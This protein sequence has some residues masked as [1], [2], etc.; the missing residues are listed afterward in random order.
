MMRFEIGWRVDCCFD[1]ALKGKG[2]RVNPRYALCIAHVQ[3]CR[4]AALQPIP[5]AF[6][7]WLD[8]PCP[9]YT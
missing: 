1:G 6:Q 2:L 9:R 3:R 5:S 7:E 4:C 8:N